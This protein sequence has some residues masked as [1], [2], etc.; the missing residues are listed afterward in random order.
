[1]NALPRIVGAALDGF[2]SFKAALRWTVHQAMLTAKPTKDRERPSNTSARS[3][4]VP[5]IDPITEV[6]FSTVSKTGMRSA[7]STSRPLHSRA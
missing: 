2:E 3:A 7:T 4:R 5:T 6:P 1:M